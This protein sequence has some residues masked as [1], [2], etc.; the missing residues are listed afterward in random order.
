MDSSIWVEFVL[1]EEWSQ[2]CQWKCV[3]LSSV[4]SI[5]SFANF[6]FVGG[7]QWGDVY[8]ATNRESNKHFLLKPVPLGCKSAKRELE[9]FNAIVKLLGK[10]TEPKQK[11]VIQT[12]YI[13][14]SGLNVIF[15]KGFDRKVVDSWTLQ[16]FY[17][18]NQFKG[19]MS[20]RI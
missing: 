7:S 11:F 2:F 12:L 1:S 6:C 13:F 5:D 19:R 16:L 20:L 15:G 4:I 10:S 3:E 14:T 9:E 18:K 8:R 17:S